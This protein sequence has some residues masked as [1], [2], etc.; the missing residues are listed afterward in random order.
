MAKSINRKIDKHLRY[1]QRED[2]G[3]PLA[4]V[5][6]AEDFFFSRHYGAAQPLLQ[7][8]KVITPDMLDVSAFMADYEQ[9]YQDSLLVEQDGFWV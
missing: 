1:W 9:M 2:T 5:T 8:G 4:S 6:I 3:R 7:P